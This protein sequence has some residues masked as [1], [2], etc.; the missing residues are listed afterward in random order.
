MFYYK[1]QKDNATSVRQF[2]E[3]A[4]SREGGYLSWRKNWFYVV[5]YLNG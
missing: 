3:M 5:V 1:S 2:S 4:V